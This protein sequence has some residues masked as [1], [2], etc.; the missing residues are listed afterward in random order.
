MYSV[1]SEGMHLAV[2]NPH[3]QCSFFPR[4]ARNFPPFMEREV[5]FMT[6]TIKALQ[7]TSSWVRRVQSTSAN[8]FILPIHLISATATATK[9]L[10]RSLPAGFITK[11]LYALLV[12]SIRAT[13]PAALFVILIYVDKDRPF[14]FFTLEDGTD[15]LSRNVGKEN[16]Q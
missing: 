11:L 1:D 10:K 12:S 15:R 2:F 8:P 5:S 13:C 9:I 7:E 14:V 4:P 6:V 3:R 16:P